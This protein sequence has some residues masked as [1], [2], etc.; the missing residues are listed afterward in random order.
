MPEQFGHAWEVSR[1]DSPGILEYTLLYR[2]VM[3]CGFPVRE[4]ENADSPG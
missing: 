4:F 3:H 1:V 2:F